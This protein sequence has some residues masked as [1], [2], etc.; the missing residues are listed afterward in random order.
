M[1]LDPLA[2][3][4]G[5]EFC[6]EEDGAGVL[7]M[8]GAFASTVDMSAASDSL[9]SSWLFVQLIHLPP[10]PASAAALFISNVAGDCDADADDCVEGALLKLAS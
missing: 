6:V 3:S 5:A 8:S 9:L 4:P 2:C 7:A 1:L 10:I